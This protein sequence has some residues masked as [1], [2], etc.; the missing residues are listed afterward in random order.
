M[1]F[2][3]Y[4]FQLC[5]FVVQI[6]FTIRQA[7]TA[8]INRHC[9]LRRVFRVLYHAHGK[10]RGDAHLIEVADQRGYFTFFLECLNARE[11]R[12]Q[13]LQTQRFAARFIH[14]AR[15]QIADFLRF[16]A[17]RFV[18]LRRDCV[19]DRAQ[20]DQRGLAQFIERTPARF[21]CRNRGIF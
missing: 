10:R 1:V 14:V 3:T 11:V 20:I 21:I 4:V 12:L 6:I 9:I 13:R 5:V 16:A 2:G 8:L 18:F 17:G 19:N 7:Q 15:I